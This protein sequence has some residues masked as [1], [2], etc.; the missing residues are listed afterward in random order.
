MAELTAGALTTRVAT[1][2]DVDAL[3]RLINAAYRVEDFF[4]HGDRTHAAEIERFMAT[5]GTVFLLLES[6]A[7]G[8]VGAVRLETATSLAHLAMLSVDPVRQGRGLGRRLLEASE[9][10]CRDAGCDALQLEVVDLRTELP[11][12]YA[13]AG[14]TV[15][16]AAPFPVLEKLRR[17]AGL[18]LMQKDLLRRPARP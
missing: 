4:V 15:T 6:K 14:Y 12:W 3:V 5:P 11:S 17:D 13:A 2:A 16:G 7:D 10:Y 18:I 1:A 9:A 8:L